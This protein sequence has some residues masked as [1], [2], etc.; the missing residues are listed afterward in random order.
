[1]LERVLE[2]LQI[3][4]KYNPKAEVCA[5]HD[6]FLIAVKKDVSE[7]DAEKLSKVHCHWMEEYDSW[8]F[9]T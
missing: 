5:I 2:G 8:G 4:H 3:L 9:Y 7:E 1:M 6:T